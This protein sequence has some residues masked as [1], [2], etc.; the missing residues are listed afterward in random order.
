M[1]CRIGL[2]NMRGVLLDSMCTYKVEPVHVLGE[3]LAKPD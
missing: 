1:R 3:I 2:L